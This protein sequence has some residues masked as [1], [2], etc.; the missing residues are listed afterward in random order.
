MPTKRIR[1]PPLGP[2]A[3]NAR[4]LENG[5]RPTGNVDLLI[6]DKLVPISLFRLAKLPQRLP[7]SIQPS[8]RSGPDVPDAPMQNSSAT[9]FNGEPFPQGHIFE[10]GQVFGASNWPLRWGIK[11]MG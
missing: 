9:F 3:L 4:E 7:Q 1:L 8:R 5:V 11:D 6:I 10:Q 2:I